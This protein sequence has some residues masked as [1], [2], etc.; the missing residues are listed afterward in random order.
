MKT[1]KIVLINLILLSICFIGFS[2]AHDTDLYMASGEGIEPN[3]LILFDNSGSMDEEVPTRSYSNSVTYDPLVVPTANRNTVYRL[4]GNNYSLFANDISNLACAAAR[5]ALTNT[6]HYTGNT[7]ASCSGTSR[8]LWTGNYRNYIASGG[9]KSDR[10][11]DIAKE[12]MTDFLSAI[13]GVKIGAMVFNNSE[14]GRIQTTIKSLTDTGRAQLITDFNAITPETWTPLAETLYE[15]GLYFRGWPSYFNS[16]VTYT[17]PIEYS[18]QRNYVIIITDGESTQDRNSILANG[19]TAHGKNYPAIGDRDGDRR[20][21]IGAANDP[22]YADSGSDYLDDVA[23]YLYETDLRTD[24]SGKQNIVTYTIGFTINNDLLNRTAEQGHGK[25]F[26]SQNAQELAS[27]FQNIIDEILSKTSSFVAPVVPVSRMERTQSGDKIYLALF[28][29]IQNGMWSGNIKK[30]GIAQQYSSDYTIKPGDIIGANNRLA[31]D[32]SGQFYETTHSYWTSSG[33]LDGGDAQKGGV[34]EVLMNRDYTVFDP[35]TGKP[36]KIY[37]YNTTVK[38][39]NLTH[40]SNVFS[41]TNI[42]P[43]M[44]GLGSDSD[45]IAQNARDKLIKFIYGYDAYDDDGNGVTDEK[46]DWILGAFLHSRPLVL[47]YGTSDTSQSVI[48]AGSNDGMLHAFDDSSGAE[49]WG[50]IPP[51]VLNNLHA[52]HEDVLQSF[53]D[54]SPKAYVTRDSSGTINKAILIFGER[55]GGNRYYA[56]DVTTPSAPKYLWEINPDLTDSPYAEMGQTWSTPYVGKIAYGTGEKWVAFVG[57]GY[58]DGQDNAIPPADLKG[59]AVYVIDVLDGSLIKRFSHAEISG[60]TYSFPSDIMRIDT[61]DDLKIDR[62]YV[63]DMGGRMWRFDIGDP[64][65]ASW[66]GKIVFTGAS[67]TKIFYPPDV[68]MEMG[69]YE[70]LFFGTGDREN[71][72]GTSPVDR[73]YAIKDKNLSTSLTESNLYDVTA[74]ELQADGTTDA[75]KAEILQALRNSSGWFI[76]LLPTSSGEKC[77]SSIVVLGKIAFY[78][79]FTPGAGGETDPCHVGEGVGR[80]YAVQYQTGNAAF[81]FDLTNDTGDLKIF[82]KEDRS[83]NIGLGIPSGV[84]VTFVGGKAVGYIGVG[85]GVAPLTP[86]TKELEQSYWRIIF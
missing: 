55:R 76:Q 8:T 24:M 60:M 59:R 83:L 32:S 61:T 54:G 42:T 79:T 85:G 34:G 70:M 20:E 27:A 21:P 9:D 43:S 6:G 48:F 41:A 73:L 72:K 37:T 52:L 28:K 51:N 38:N 4:Q 22:H 50:F 66:T 15:I 12:V 29:P 75:R 74:D 53:V 80:V 56:L 65:P 7:N 10:K 30:Y 26:Y 13:N 36:R 47:H 86:G 46:K 69:G 45:S 67:G 84:V 64:N 58:D 68:T 62:L 17:S 63:G 5:T 31:L 1:A 57:G 49:L 78:T 71:P 44:L 18:C 2:F 82:R 35:S 16:G 19:A 23:R 11:I 39:S 14:G 3:I 77:L 25:Y 40:S 33:V 81:N